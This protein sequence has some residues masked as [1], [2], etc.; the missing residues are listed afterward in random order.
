MRIL[1]WIA[2]ALIVVFV[3]IALGGLALD[4]IRAYDSPE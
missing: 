1:V 4:I 2:A 3:V